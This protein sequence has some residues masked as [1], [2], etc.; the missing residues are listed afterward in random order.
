M[1]Q[2]K[3]GKAI[4]RRAQSVNLLTHRLLSPLG[5]QGGRCQAKTEKMPKSGTL[6]VGEAGPQ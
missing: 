5:Q 6:E 1:R 2:G 3:V 4:H